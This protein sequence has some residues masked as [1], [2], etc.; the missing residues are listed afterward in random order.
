M[1]GSIH[2][3]KSDS[4]RLDTVFVLR[5]PPAKM[6]K[7]HD[8]ATLLAEQVDHLE[9]A[10]LHLTTGDR[11]CLAY[12][13]IAEETVRAL[14][15]GWKASRAVEERMACAFEELKKRAEARVAVAAVERTAIAD[16]SHQLELGAEVA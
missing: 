16:P 10:G 13:L 6:P 1:R 2:I 8:L 9:R 5:K 14:R 7:R 11:R 12:G 15:D 4:S 3:A